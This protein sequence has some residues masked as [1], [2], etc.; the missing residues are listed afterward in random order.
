MELITTTLYVMQNLLNKD[1]EIIRKVKEIK[2]SKYSDSEILGAIK[3]LRQD[4]LIKKA[5]L[6]R[7]KSV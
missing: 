6:S 7:S 1:P 2:G 3:T 4:E 5:T